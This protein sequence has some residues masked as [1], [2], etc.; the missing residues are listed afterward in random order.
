[1]IAEQ[2][3]L[4]LLAV[5]AG[6][7]GGGLVNWAADVLPKVTQMKRSNGSDNEP[8]TARGDAVGKT[9]LALNGPHRGWRL[10]HLG[11]AALA[12]SEGCTGRRNLTVALTS[13][14]L[15]VLMSARWGW[16]IQMGIGWLYMLFLLAVTVIDLEHHRVLNI[17]LAPAAIVVTALSLLP[18]GPGLSSALLGGVVGFGI[19]FLLA[20]AGRGALGMGDVKLAGVIGMMLGYPYVVTALLAGTLLGGV[21][22]FVLLATQRATRKTAI[23]YAPY[24]ACGAFMTIWLQ[25]SLI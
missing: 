11:L 9:A 24:L 25:F 14:L 1:M 20:L 3:G 18:G 12:G 5:L 2:I 21:A 6:W 22:A 7:I 16:S 4:G 23:A 8:D 13:V 10:H 19:F 15:T 17:M